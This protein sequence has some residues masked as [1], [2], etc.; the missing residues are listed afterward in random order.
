MWSTW[1]SAGVRG[2]RR[3]GGTRTRHAG[4]G[5]G[6]SELGTELFALTDNILAT[7]ALLPTDG[8]DGGEL[9]WLGGGWGGRGGERG[10]KREE[11]KRSEKKRGRRE[12]RHTLIVF[13][14]RFDSEFLF[15]VGE[16]AIDGVWV[17]DFV[18]DA[19]ES[20]SDQNILFLTPLGWRREGG[21][22]ERDGKEKR[23]EERW[24][25]RERDEWKRRERTH[26]F[27]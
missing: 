10:K 26:N 4:G 13:L 18:D 8:E 22:G 9:R 27:L 16:E 11:K 2:I 6:D 3:Y 24:R 1:D 5:G 21:D 19:G 12:G 20:L 15:V 14:F 25:E 17:V 7:L 23:V